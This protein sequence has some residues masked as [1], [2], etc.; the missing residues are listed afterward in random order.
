MYKLVANISFNRS[1]FG[2]N[3]FVFYVSFA[4]F[5]LSYNDKMH[6]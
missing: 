3:I 5:Y 1:S 4:L 2:S 6:V